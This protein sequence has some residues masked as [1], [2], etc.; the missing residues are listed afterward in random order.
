[1]DF[2]R[3][4]VPEN[5]DLLHVFVYQGLELLVRAEVDRVVTSPKAESKGLPERNDLVV[6]DLLL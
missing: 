6:S 2:P 1:V 5:G 3:V 4:P